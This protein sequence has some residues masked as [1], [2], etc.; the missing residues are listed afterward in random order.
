MFY[1][2]WGICIAFVPEQ[3]CDKLKKGKGGTAEGIPS[4]SWDSEA[5]CVWSTAA[6]AATAGDNIVS[7]YFHPYWAED[8]TVVCFSLISGPAAHLIPY[9]IGSV[10]HQRRKGDISGPWR[11][12]GWGDKNITGNLPHFMLH[13]G[14]SL[15]VQCLVH[16]AWKVIIVW[17][18]VS[19]S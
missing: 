19:A 5:K 13:T 10:E 3:L 14:R 7:N 9:C 12:S 2:S 18:W 15:G 11:G 6:K 1:K 8:L 4:G 17:Q 16:F